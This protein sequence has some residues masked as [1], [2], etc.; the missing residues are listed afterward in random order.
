MLLIYEDNSIRTVVSTANLV[1][2]DWENRTQGLWVSP[3]C[4]PGDGD[5]V[6][7]FKVHVLPIFLK[8]PKSIDISYF[9]YFQASL[10][11][12]LE[13]YQVSPLKPY[14]D[15]VKKCDLSQ[16]NAIFI[17]SSPGSHQGSSLCH[18]GHMAVGS[19]LR[20]HMKP[21]NWPLIMQCS[22]IG[23]T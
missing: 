6:T 9:K 17:G 4:P 22:S 13:S 12:Y 5:S 3:K 18:F 15:H 20:K 10:I 2:S 11:R 8:K 7:G 23:I 1:P 14:I 16:I 19:A 21:C